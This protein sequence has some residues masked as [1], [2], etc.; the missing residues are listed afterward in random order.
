MIP[1]M[2]YR[3]DIGERWFDELP[4]SRQAAAKEIYERKR[5]K[6][7][8][9]GL[10]ECLY[11]VDWISLAGRCDILLDALGFDRKSFSKACGRLPDIR[12]RC[13]L[14]RLG[15]RRGGARP[16]GVREPARHSSSAIC[17]AFRAAPLRS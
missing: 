16:H 15:P 1:D 4:A 3:D 12:P 17:T 9:I 14:K 5:A 7:A 6:S 8:E 13:C 11:F 2:Y 10:E